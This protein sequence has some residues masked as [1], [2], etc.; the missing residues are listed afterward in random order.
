MRTRRPTASVAPR[1]TKSGPH[2]DRA[3]AWRRPKIIGV[4]QRDRL[5]YVGRSAEVL[6]ESVAVFPDRPGLRVE[7][8][9][10]G[11]LDGDVGAG[12]DAHVDPDPRRL[13]GFPALD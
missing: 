10:T 3:P 4:V 11:L 1:L 13:I 8:G 7:V 6:D 5:G 9:L 2:N 12:G